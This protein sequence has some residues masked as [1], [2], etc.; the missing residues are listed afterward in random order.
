MSRR[1]DRRST[2]HFD[3]IPPSV[4]VATPGPS[5]L[6]EQVTV[7]QAETSEEPVVENGKL[8]NDEEE[9]EGDETWDNFTAEY[10]EGEF[11]DVSDAVERG[12]EG[13][14]ENEKKL[15]RIENVS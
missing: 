15:T 1:R 10:Y 8:G 6:R 13:E 7:Q 4:P 3:D 14:W 5:R 12:R 2:R 9:E 11:V